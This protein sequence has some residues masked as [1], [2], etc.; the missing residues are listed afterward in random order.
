MQPRRWDKLWRRPGEHACVGALQ[1][2]LLAAW[3]TPRCCA[4]LSCVRF[5]CAQAAEAG[6]RVAGAAAQLA[7]MAAHRDMLSTRLSELDDE[8]RA[9][10]LLQIKV[11]GAGRGGAGR[12]PIAC[13]LTPLLLLIAGKTELVHM[14]RGQS[15]KQNGQPI[16]Q[17][18]AM[19]LGVS[20]AA[21]RQRRD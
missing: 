1:V 9:E 14:W 18:T 2:F 10:L 15:R 6:D 8:R 21:G 17:I 3:G 11:S 16:A 12:G 4:Q 20:S 19:L 13:R 7:A 5:A